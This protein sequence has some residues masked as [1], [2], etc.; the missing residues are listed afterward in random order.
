MR[1]VLFSTIALFALL[2]GSCEQLPT[3]NNINV[4]GGDK[5]RVTS[6]TLITMPAE[7]GNAEI[8]FV[9]DSE[10]EGAKLTASSPAEWITNFEVNQTVTFTVAPNTDVAERFEQIELTYAD[11]MVIVAVSQQ[12]RAVS[13]DAKLTV[14]SER[15]MNFEATGGNGTITYTLTNAEE[16]DKP[17]VQSNDIWISIRDIRSDEIAFTVDANDTTSSRYGSITV[18]YGKYK[19]TINIAQAEPSNKPVLSANN[20]NVKFGESIKFTVVHLNKDVT[21]SSTIYDY[22]TRTEVPNP[23]TPTEAKEYVFF[24]K[25]DGVNSNVYTVNV[26]PSDTPDLPVDTAP[27]SYDFNQRMLIVDHTGTGCPNC[28]AVKEVFKAAEENANYNY[29]FTPVFSYSYSSGELCYSSAAKTLWNYYKEVCKSGDQ[30][31][32]FPSFTTNFCF[33]YTGKFNLEQRIDDFWVEN[34]TASIALSTKRDGN[35]LVVNAAVKS[36]KTQTI[37]LALWLLEDDIYSIQSG[38]NVPTWMHTHH[39]VMRDALTGVSS[40]DIAGIEFGYVEAYTT[41]ERV[42]TFDL[43]VGNSWNIEN[44]KLI[45]IISAPNSEYNGKFEVVNTAI[46]EFNDSVGFDYKK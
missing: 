24:A 15:T 25:Y 40:T 14:T 30:L 21:A 46:C 9:I 39:N 12:G 6:N 29:K 3:D 11:T 4:G 5:F 7:G 16:G 42:M 22:Y 23:Y 13:E 34:P 33:N 35:K 19:I 41:Y 18:S 37:K 17:A 44:C 38:Y 43:F 2:F 28:P 27:D 1:R 8:E 32:G 10:V 45:A 36:T 26:V 20:A 31:T